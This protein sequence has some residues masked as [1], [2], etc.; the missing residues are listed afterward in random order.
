MGQTGPQ[1]P[2]KVIHVTSGHGAFDSRIF[3]KECC[4]LAKAGFET[5]LVIPGSENGLLS[6][7]NVHGVSTKWR[8]RWERFTST[9][10]A[11]IDRAIELDGD[12]YHLHDPTLLPFARTLKK[13]GKKVIYDSHEDFPLQTLSKEF[14]PAGLRYMA[15]IGVRHFENFF[16][17]YIDAVVTATPS[18]SLRFQSF[19]VDV[20][21]VNNFPIIEELFAPADVSWES[22]QQAVCYIGGIARIR[23]IFEM[24]QA[25]EKINGILYLAGT[26]PAEIRKDVEATSGWSH[27]EEMGFVGRERVRKILEKSRAGLVLLH[28]VPNYIESL[29]IK[30]FEYMSAGLPVICSDFSF[31]RKIVQ[32]NHCGLCVDPRK[33]K[34]IS[35]AISFILSEPEKAE[36]MGKAGL[37]IVRKHYNWQSEEQKLIQLY[38]K[39]CFGEELKLAPNAVLA[40]LRMESDPRKSIR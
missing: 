2:Q 31:W 16:A 37:E 11:V 15:S 18:I 9:G 8:T 29:P 19:G 30:M 21:N 32:Q 17:R 38:R 33:P 28:P 26:M 39:V 20:V 23:G 14:I 10:K 7:V 27:I 1:K 5:H 12:V 36:K 4:S 34:E 6:G 25:M 24:V 13:L 40:E 22:R 3:V 35:D